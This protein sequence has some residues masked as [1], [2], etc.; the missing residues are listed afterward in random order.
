MRRP[1]LLTTLLD[2]LFTNLYSAFKLTLFKRIRVISLPPKIK[3]LFII[4]PKI[5]YL[6]LILNF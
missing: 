6:G 4:I 1:I 2:N 5:F 3:T